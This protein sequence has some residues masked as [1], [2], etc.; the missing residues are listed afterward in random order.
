MKERDA[1]LPLHLKI[2]RNVSG[3]GKHLYQM[4]PALQRLSETAAL[5]YLLGSIGMINTKMVTIKR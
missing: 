2:Y 4:I 1:E 5:V 3:V